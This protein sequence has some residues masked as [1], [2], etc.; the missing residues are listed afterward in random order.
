MATR[1]HTALQQ[2]RTQTMPLK[3]KK[4]KKKKLLIASDIISTLLYSTMGHFVAVHSSA[5][6][7]LE[8]ASTK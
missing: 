2:V 3:M 5:G 8:N 6:I 7:K 4:K 1:H